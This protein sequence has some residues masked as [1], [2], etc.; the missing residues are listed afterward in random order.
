MR[1]NADCE[2]RIEPVPNAESLSI[3]WRVREVLAEKAS[4]KKR[5]AFIRLAMNRIR[6]RRAQLKV[7]AQTALDDLLN[8]L[9]LKGPGR[10]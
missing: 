9:Q 7:S 10:N 6:L 1:R 8:S 4:G 3:Q 5:T 2:W